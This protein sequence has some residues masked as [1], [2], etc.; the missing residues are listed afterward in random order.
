MITI[1][2]SSLY[3]VA[4]SCLLIATT[5]YSHTRWNP[6]GELKPRQ[7]ADGSYPDDIKT[8]PCGDLPR[9]ENPVELIAGSTIEVEFQST[10]YHQGAFRIAFAQANDEGFDDNVLV[11]N[12]PD[13]P[14]QTNRSV[15]ITLPDVTCEACTL[16][17]I[18]SMLDR[19]PPT[20]YFS[21]TDIRLVDGS[22]QPVE[23]ATDFDATNADGQITLTWESTNSVVIF[24]SQS[25]ELP[26]PQIGQGFGVGDS[27]GD[28]TVVY[29]GSDLELALDHEGAD[30]TLYYSIFA[31]SDD[32]SY[33]AGSSVS[34]TPTA[35]SSSQN[36]SSSSSASSEASS[37]SS[38]VGNGD[39]TGGALNPWAIFGILL[40]ALATQL[41]RSRERE[42]A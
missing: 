30:Q 6:D 32:Y 9:S 29:V 22:A 13:D 19:N 28:A 27:V 10:I 24:E 42:R 12:I 17:L 41:G 25:S 20:N 1:K 35:S 33:S 7:R 40:A 26:Q 36:S 8:G 21:C 11:D 34:V 14:N 3:L 2:Q 5:G 39:D 15:S 38:Q 4:M 18:Q 31:F 16:Q 37:S 23:A